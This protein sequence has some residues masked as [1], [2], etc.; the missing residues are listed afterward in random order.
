MIV[1]P[2]DARL[3]AGAAAGAAAA[4]AGAVAVAVAGSA[5]Q[6]R[7]TGPFVLR[8]NVAVTHMLEELILEMC[9]WQRFWG[10]QIIEV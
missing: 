5:G 1:A 4:G 7:P 9:L 6:R 10:V 8:F 2:R 3:A